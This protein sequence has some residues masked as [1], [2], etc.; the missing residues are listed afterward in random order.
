MYR[1]SFSNATLAAFLLFTV[2]EEAIIS[3]S[4][5]H[6][7]AH[8]QAIHDDQRSKCP[9]DNLPKTVTNDEWTLFT[10]IKKQRSEGVTCPS[11][12]QY[13]PNP[14]PLQ[15]DCRLWRA[16]KVQAQL[17]ADQDLIAQDS[18]DGCTFQQRLAA[19]RTVA[20]QELLAAGK[21]SPSQTLAQ[22]QASP[23]EYCDSIFLPDIMFFGGAHG[24]NTSSS[25]K[26]Y[27]SHVLSQTLPH[28]EMLDTSCHPRTAKAHN[29]PHPHEEKVAFLNPGEEKPAL[30]DPQ[31]KKGPAVT[32]LLKTKGPAFP[33]P[34]KTKGP[35]FP[36][37]Q[38]KEERP[39]LPLPQGKKKQAPLPLPQEKKKQAPL[40]L[41]QK[42]EQPPFPLP[43]EKKKQ[44]LS[45]LPRPVFPRPYLLELAAVAGAAS[46]TASAST[47]M[48][49]EAAA[50]VAAKAAAE[51][52]VRAA[53]S[54]IP[55]FAPIATLAAKIA[56]QA[57]CMP[58]Y[59]AREVAARAMGKVAGEEAGKAKK[60]TSEV[61]AATS[62]ATKLAAVSEGMSE[63][64]AEELAS[65]GPALA[66]AG[67][68]GAEA[69]ARAA[70]EDVLRA[71][72]PVYEIPECP[73]DVA[74]LHRRDGERP[75]VSKEIKSA[76]V[77]DGSGK[78]REE[79]A[80]PMAADVGSRTAAGAGAS[81]GQAVRS[82]IV[83]AAGISRRETKSPGTLPTEAKAPL[84]TPLIRRE[85]TV[86]APTPP[87]P[88][89]PS[90]EEP[91]LVGALCA[92]T[93]LEKCPLSFTDPCRSL[94]LAQC[95]S[96]FHKC[97]GNGEFRAC[98][99]QDEVCK[100]AGN[101]CLLQ[102]A[103]GTVP[104]QTEPGRWDCARRK[105]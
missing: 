6:S 68:E 12:R 66:D 23:Y 29:L 64:A 40:P 30:P 58:D 25:Y 24:Y 71:R 8:R 99:L 84:Q 56:A 78:A 11:G 95:V 18:R 92:G 79:A 57:A 44:A 33:D 98:H 17:M 34:Q 86:P 90:E 42:K 76:V 82:A 75:A 10:L 70:A 61:A 73:Y 69:V 38:K 65:M 102:C 45:P 41:P 22:L 39:P 31:T 81:Q 63:T 51:V 52:V 9:N 105:H 101:A 67:C 96:I 49:R 91:E 89:L 47:G 7:P 53:G 36:D 77:I 20:S 104:H 83:A 43:L 14:M 72:R 15:L 48:P 62:V 4:K 87:T 54:L 50:G 80:R 1:S 28:G 88:S 60:T 55:E 94:T 100:A 3:H 37:P 21:V 16:A 103:S 26:H 97:G 59:L 27:W 5:E 35:A 13:K 93:Y 74:G 32:K 19:Q 85:V 2:T 46:R